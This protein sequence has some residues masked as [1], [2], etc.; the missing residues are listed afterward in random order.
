MSSSCCSGN[1]S[2]RSLGSSLRCPA[3]SCGS[4]HP[5]NLVPSRDLCS[6]SPCPRGP[7]LHSGY[8]VTCWAPSSCRPSCCS[9]RVSMLGSPCQ[10]PLPGALGWGSSN[11]CSLGSGAGGLRP[12]GYRVCGVP[13]L[14]PGS[15]SCR[16]T[17]GTSRSCQT[18]CYR[19]ACGSSCY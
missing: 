7:S 5:S 6:S 9:P 18:S 8:Q 3:S 4:S 17:C 15:G 16:P 13:V 11:S 10:T 19:P 14:S 1:F 12:L 2:S